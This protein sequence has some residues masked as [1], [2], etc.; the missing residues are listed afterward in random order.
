MLLAA[1]CLIV[2]G[3]WVLSTAAGLIAAGVCLAS[4]A[5]ITLVEMP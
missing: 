2:A 5:L 3:F 4:W 1:S